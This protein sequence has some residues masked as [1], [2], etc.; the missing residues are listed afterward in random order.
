MA[1]SKAAWTNQCELRATSRCRFSPTGTANEQ[2]ASAFAQIQ[3][4][5]GQEGDVKQKFVEDNR[6]AVLGANVLSIDTVLG[7][8]YDALEQRAAPAEMPVLDRELYLSLARLKCTL[9]DAS[10]LQNVRGDGFGALYPTI[11]C[12]TQTLFCGW[13][14]APERISRSLSDLS[15]H[16]HQVAEAILL[17][18]LFVYQQ[19]ICPY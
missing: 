14:L 16:H 9:K 3:K 7:D 17:I 2:L 5:V 4:W 6:G 10:D 12:A 15:R 8:I 13:L 19:G 1:C 18:Q 11:A